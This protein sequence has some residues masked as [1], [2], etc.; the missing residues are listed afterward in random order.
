MVR[1][2]G[3]R[4]LPGGDGVVTKRRMAIMAGAGLALALLVF[5][6]T[7]PSVLSARWT[8]AL[9]AAG[10]PQAVLAV[11]HLGLG[12][13]TGAFS[14]GGEQ[15]AEAVAIAFTP[16]GL[17][18]G[19]AASV[20]V[21]GLRLLL[22]VGAGGVRL[23]AAG[24]LPLDG[25]LTLEQAHLT[26]VP[27]TGLPPLTIDADGQWLPDGD[28]WRGTLKGRAAMA[29]AAA[30]A[31]LSLALRDG[32]LEELGFALSPD[33]GPQ[34]PS[35]SGKGRLRW[36]D[37]QFAV[38]EMELEARRLREGAPDLSVS[39][40]NGQGAATLQW[41]GIARADVNLRPTDKGWARL[42][43][44]LAV[45][46]LRPFL[47]KLG[48]AE[49]ALGDGSVEVTALAEDID[50]AGW[51][52]TAPAVD[53]RL[54]A[55]G[56]AFGQGPRDNSLILVATATRRDGVWWLAGGGAGGTL[57][58]PTLGVDARGLVVTGPVALPLDL[59][60][61]AASV[62]LPWLPPLPVQA[63]LRG[64]PAGDLR[65]EWNAA[66]AAD[67]RL[68]GAVDM[69]AGGSSGRLSLALAPL[70][71][72]R[73]GATARD[74]LPGAPLPDGLTGTLAARITAGW[75]EGGADGAA[76]ILLDDVGLS[77]PGLR[78]AGVNGVLRFDRL[79]PLSM[80]VQRLSIGLADVGIPL[81]DGAVG[82]AL[83]GDGLLRL[84]PE[85]FRWAG[86][87]VT[88]APAL[89]RLGQD[90]VDMS[91][92]IAQMP[93]VPAL[94]S[95]GVTGTGADGALIGTVPLRLSAD[96]AVLGPGSLRAAQP[97]RIAIAGTEPPD[98][99]DRTRNDS[100]ALVGR[101]LADYRYDQLELVLSGNGHRLVL[102]GANPMLY[103]GYRMPLSLVLAPLPAAE[104]P[105]SPVP[106]DV[107]AT[108]EAFRARKD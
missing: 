33:G 66:A 107:A 14:L 7:L 86:T 30:G 34:A 74:L 28:G 31:D 96:G 75:H 73:G 8:A 53:L 76:D 83:G 92:N 57:S 41:P 82:L 39:W 81:L 61:G 93:L 91:L 21:R 69:A 2:K 42:E 4:D 72:G 37:R 52:A 99:L 60:I 102:D 45:A 43:A 49:P 70:R 22:P 58:I 94:A 26:L 20:H 97:G 32:A 36:K 3:R 87:P 54:T 11:D 106:D 71:L 51:P 101:A 77:A 16:A 79:S 13:A 38:A 40:R 23:P 46:A 25:P 19:R 63:R 84:S 64:E 108:M 78:L 55:R 44:K 29:G 95:L 89:Y 47:Q 24:G 80:P 15:G 1:S 85:P 67:F 18:H 59:Q 27:P 103:G 65:L 98:W 10:Y 50:L 68:S 5:W 104:S 56:V 88:V 100:L 90:H 6:L 48:W 17:W 9:R 35:L 62:R 12:T 105:A